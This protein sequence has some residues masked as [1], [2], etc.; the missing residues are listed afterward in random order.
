MILLNINNNLICV[1]ED[2]VCEL[3]RSS[4]DLIELECFRMNARL[5]IALQKHSPKLLHVSFADVTD[6]IIIS[7]CKS[8]P[9]LK[10][11]LLFSA[12]KLTDAAAEAIAAHLPELE[13]LPLLGWNLLTDRGLTALAELT[14]LNGLFL[15]GNLGFTNTSVAS[16]VRNNPGIRKM[17]L[18]LRDNAR[19]DAR[20]FRHI[21]GYCD[22]LRGLKIEVEASGGIRAPTP[23][24]TSFLPTDE[25]LIPLI[26]NCPIL[27]T[28]DI[29]CA[30]QLTE[31]LLIALASNCP[32]L[33]SIDLTGHTAGATPALITDEGIAALV[34]GC[35]KLE[36][37]SIGPCPELTD[38]GILSVAQHCKRLSR[39]FMEYNDKI[40]DDGMRVLFK[41]CTLLT[42]V[43]VNQLRNLT[44][45]G[46]LALPL[47]CHQLSVLFLVNMDVTD[48]FF[49]AL[50]QHC[51]K[52]TQLHLYGYTFSDNAY[53]TLRYLL[54]DC[55]C[56]TELI[57]NT[58]RGI[59]NHTVINLVAN[60]SKQ[61]KRLTIID[62]LDLQY[63]DQLREV[64]KSAPESMNLSVAITHAM[65][66]TAFPAPTAA[67]AVP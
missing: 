65:M 43:V 11:L 49:W 34:A 39:L 66:S 63:D 13:M 7:F 53:N 15:G 38:Q 45:E 55:P 54:D 30:S 2:L 64:T 18:V 5:L 62:C 9:L 35:P 17:S 37:L 22:N 6:S 52:L 44:D 59:T 31:R 33:T 20:V 58:C 26:R 48:V 19:Y 4:P 21:A 8:F 24:S 3:L 14:G 23:S 10:R 57:L 16:V 27:Q 60:H 12:K 40:T 42:T 25:D 56:L 47:H 61:I 46:M 36:N 67:P 51:P 29:D 41:S 1:D 28:I 32:K 50:A